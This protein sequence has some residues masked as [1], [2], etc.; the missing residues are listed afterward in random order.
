MT[1]ASALASAF[2]L[3]FSCVGFE[4]GSGFFEVECV[5]VDDQLVF[6]SVIGDGED[7]V[8]CVAMLPEGLHDEI[9]VYHAR[10]FTA[11]LLRRHL[12]RRCASLEAIQQ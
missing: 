6:A 2:R 3:L 11:V 9:D 12:R 7:T 5:A 4:D 10:E 8:H 1:A